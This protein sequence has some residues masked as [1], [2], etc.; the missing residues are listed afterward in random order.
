MEDQAL[1]TAAAPREVAPTI[2]EVTA[3]IAASFTYASFQNAIPVMR[4]IAISNHTDK[5][6]ENCRIDLAASPP[7]LRAKSWTIDRLIPGD[8][9]L[10]NDRKI[11]LDENYLS[12]LN[13]AERGEITLRLS[14]AVTARVSE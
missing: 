2:P 5:H 11:D 7:F 9:I 13:E 14:C 3:D 4:S 1:E 8:D 12:G 6:F 10:L